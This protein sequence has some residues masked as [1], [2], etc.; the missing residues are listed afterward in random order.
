M[1]FFVIYEGEQILFWRFIE[2]I[3]QFDFWILVFVASVS[4][5]LLIT[6]KHNGPKWE[7]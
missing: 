6:I 5:D 4:H 7:W 3:E 2:Q 1:S